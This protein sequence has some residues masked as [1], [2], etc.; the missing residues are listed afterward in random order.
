MKKL[1]KLFANDNMN[2]YKKSA[3]KNTKLKMQKG[4]F[5]YNMSKFECIT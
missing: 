4:D 1:R 2:Q 5:L 3:T